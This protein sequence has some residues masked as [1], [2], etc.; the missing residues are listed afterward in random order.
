[1]GCQLNEWR[2]AEQQSHSRHAETFLIVCRVGARRDGEQ[3]PA[4]PHCPTITFI[5][6][7]RWQRGRITAAR[8]YGK[9]S[10]RKAGEP[11]MNAER[12]HG[13]RPDD[14]EARTATR[15][16]VR[17]EYQRGH[18]SG[19]RSDDRGT[20]FGDRDE[21]EG[22]ERGCTRSHLAFAGPMGDDATR[23][24]GRTRN[25]LRFAARL[26]CFFRACA[27]ANGEA[28]ADE[29]AVDGSAGGG[30]GDDSVHR[31]DTEGVWDGR[32]LGRRRG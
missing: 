22:S 3:P 18:D 8:E 12:R 2:V 15:A 6:C 9:L 5:R 7:V 32:E 4:L 14:T 17:V 27:E 1:M 16:E 31:D 25:R 10:Q 24:R 30:G 21:G 11:T 26:T 29:S 28:D 20:A 13:G 23:L 19:R